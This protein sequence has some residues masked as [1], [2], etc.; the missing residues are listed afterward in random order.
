MSK[1]IKSTEVISFTAKVFD[2]INWIETD[3]KDEIQFSILDFGKG[4]QLRVMF[5]DQREKIKRDDL[6][7]SPEDTE[8]FKNMLNILI[9]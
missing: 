6:I 1:I 5:N 8:K 7:F 4:S 9:K 3:K 2:W